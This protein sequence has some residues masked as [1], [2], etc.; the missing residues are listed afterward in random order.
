MSQ[1]DTRTLSKK[2]RKTM[3]TGNIGGHKNV[4]IP[5]TELQMKTHHG[6]TIGG[7]PV[8]SPSIGKLGDDQVA[9][10]QGDGKIH[11]ID[12][13]DFEIGAVGHLQDLGYTVVPPKK[14]G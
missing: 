7:I 8:N 6:T 4:K 14:A 12:A 3:L 2:L 1:L 9:F 13:D 10:M 11:S 5:L